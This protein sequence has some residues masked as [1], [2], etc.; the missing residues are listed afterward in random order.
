MVKNTLQL[1]SSSGS[2]A[3]GPARMIRKRQVKTSRGEFPTL[4]GV[5]RQQLERSLTKVKAM[6]Q[7]QFT[8]SLIDCGVLTRSGKSLAKPYRA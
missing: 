8:Q 2:V 3:F 1:K 6:T 5:T 7:E 4:L